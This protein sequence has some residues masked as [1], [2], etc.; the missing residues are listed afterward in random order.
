MASTY[1]DTVRFLVSTVLVA[2]L[3]SAL[4][5]A[6]NTVQAGTAPAKDQLFTGTVTAIDDATLTV[7]RT[8]LGK[9]S[10]TKTFQITADTRFEGGKPQVRAQV[11]VRYVASEEG[12]RAV[13][14]I[15]R[16]PPK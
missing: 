11:T 10:S 15:L 12:D 8:V 6:Q 3:S 16:R 4:I 9:N 1:S 5:F 7:M 2:L 13:H 14:V